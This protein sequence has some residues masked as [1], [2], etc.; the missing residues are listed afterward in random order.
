M[1]AQ[2][3]GMVIKSYDP[4]MKPDQISSKGAQPVSSVE[5]LFECQFVS[6]HIP[7]TEQT[8]NC[9]N[10]T[11]MGK[12]PKNAILIN[13]ARPEVVHEDDLLSMFDARADFSYVSDVIPKNMEAIKASLGESFTKRCFCTKK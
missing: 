1:I 4:F 9:I 12:M 13:S 2:G 5:E 3:F 6:L 7:F 11:L 10:S 8:K